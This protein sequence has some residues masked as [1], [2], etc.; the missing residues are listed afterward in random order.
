MVLAWLVL[1]SL[2]CAQVASSSWQWHVGIQLGEPGGWVRVRENHVRGTRLRI[3]NDLHVRSQQTL[4]LGAWRRLSSDSELHLGFTTSRLYGHARV[5]APVHFN[6]TT[7]AT[8]SLDTVTGFK[9]FMRFAVSYRRLLVD[10][11]DGGSLWGSAGAEYVLL[12][13]RLRGQIAPS[14]IGH[15]LK[16]DFYV[17]ELPVPML[18]LHLRYPL[19]HGWLLKA[20]YE[21]GRLPWVNSLRTEG[22]EVRLAQTV[23]HARLGL[24]YP[25]SRHWNLRAYVFHDALVQSER[26]REDGNFIRLHATGAGLGLSYEP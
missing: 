9:D 2:A 8:G 4:R 16:E 1:P 12:N 23:V 17:Q 5:T 11:G 15:E 14:S 3:R 6:G 25:L 24:E 22:G 21:A 13:F 18:G 19:A 7:V 26:S 20:G 10:F